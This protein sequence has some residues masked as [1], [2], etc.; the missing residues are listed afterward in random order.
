MSDCPA[1]ARTW[2]AEPLGDGTTRFRLWAPA[3][4]RVWLHGGGRDR[5][6]RRSDDGW[7]ELATDAVAPGDGYGFR[8]QDGLVVPDPA[9][10]AQL[11]DV[12]GLSRLADPGAWRWRTTG[13]HGRPWEEA[14]IYELHVG[15]FSGSGTFAGVAERLDHLAGLGVT[16]IELMPV[17]QFAGRRGWGYDGV[18][19]YAPHEAYGGPEGLK[20]LVD[21]AHA[22]GLMVLLDVVYNHFGPDGNYLHLYAPEFFHAG[23][24]TPWGSAIAYEKPPVRRFFCENVLYWLEEYRLD[25][26]RFDAI[27]QIHD[28]SPEPILEEMARL[29]RE[30]IRDRHV[31]LTSEDSSN[32]I[33]L[34]RRDA[35]GGTPLFTAEWNDDFHNAVHAAVTGESEGYYRDFAADHWAK[36]ARSLAEGFVYQGE[37]S[38]HFGDRPRGEPSAGLPPVAFVDFL[39]NHDQVGNR[40]FGERL[41]DLI[42][43]PMLELLTAL[44]LLGP[45]IPLLFMGEEWAERRPFCFFTDFRGELAE[46]VREGRRLE[47]RAWSAFADEASR[48]HIPDPN[49]PTTFAASTLDWQRLDDPDGRR[50]LGLV[51]RLLEIRH[52]EVV[53]RLAGLGGHCGRIRAQHDGVVAVTWTLTDG[54]RLQIDANLEREERPAEPPPPG[55]LLFELAEGAADGLA[56]GRLPPCS[57]VVSLDRSPAEASGR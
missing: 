21:A 27:D 41:S 12:H 8:L 7:F 22:R 42:D 30:R 46:A 1:S 3:Q 20:A 51:R 45:S 31:H 32:E 40:A 25:G 23:R 56:E 2:G 10:R 26:L 14:V 9:A 15:T 34:H 43:R 39:Q 50:Q 13:W 29:V 4:A 5:P 35:E 17:A 38:E 11:G 6:M 33:R 18:L 57:I 47:F 49:D 37:L 19:L 53:P 16:A 48:Q 52:R 44:L 28:P 36:L 55:R 24:Q 54:S